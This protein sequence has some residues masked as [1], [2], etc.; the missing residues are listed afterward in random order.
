MQPSPRHPS[1]PALPLGFS[2]RDCLAGNEERRLSPLFKWYPLFGCLMSSNIFAVC[3][4]IKS[5]NSVTDKIVVVSN[6][7]KI[8]HERICCWSII[9]NITSSHQ[10]SLFIRYQHHHQ[11]HPLV[12]RDHEIYYTKENNA[13]VPNTLQQTE[14]PNT[15]YYQWLSEKKISK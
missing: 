3:A 14:L 7:D 6:Q 13:K 15:N 10:V 5:Y 4:I 2:P 11:Q 1:W 12:S 8:W 9:R